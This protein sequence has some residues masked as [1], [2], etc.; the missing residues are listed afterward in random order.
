MPPEKGPDPEALAALDRLREQ[1]E[2]TLNELRTLLELPGLPP[3]FAGAAATIDL[4]ER[5]R[6]WQ[7]LSGPAPPN[8]S[9]TGIEI[10][11]GIQ[12]FRP[13][14]NISAVTGRTGV[15]PEND[16]PLVARKAT[17]L[18]IY[19]Q[20]VEDVSGT[21]EWRTMGTATWSPPLPALAQPLGAPLGDPLASR[22]SI[23]G[24]LNFRVPAAT[25]VGNLEVRLTFTA[26][27]H[28]HP[29][30]VLWDLQGHA[31]F[32]R[33]LGALWT[34]TNILQLTFVAVNPLGVRLVRM[35]Y[36]GRGLMLAAPTVA[37]F[38]STSVQLRRMYP[39]SDICLWRESEELYD[40]DFS[41]ITPGAQHTPGTPNGGTTGDWLHIMNNMIVLENA[42]G[43]VR[44]V[45]LYPNG[46][47]GASP[48]IGWGIGRTAL[49]PVDNQP[50]LAHEVGH[51]CGRPHAPCGGPAAPDPWY[52]TYGSYSSASIG[53][54]GIDIATLAIMDPATY[55]DF[56]SYCGPPWIS[57]YQYEHIRNWLLINPGPTTCI[58][59]A[60]AL[61]ARAVHEETIERLA[62]SLQIHRSGRVR[63]SQPCF[64]L[65][66]RAGADDG[67]K[68]DYFVE[69]CNQDADA[70][71]SLRL[72]LQDANQTLD[73]AVT[74][75]FALVPWNGAAA[76]IVVLRG[77]D[78]LVR[79]PIEGKAPR[80]SRPV[81]QNKKSTHERRLS[82]K[83][84]V[85]AARFAVRY[86]ANAGASWRAIATWLDQPSCEI[87]L[88]ALPGSDAGVFEIL[89]S[90]GFR[91]SR[92]SVKLGRVARGAMVAQIIFP[93]PKLVVRVGE[94]VI[95]LG[96]A[97]GKDGEAPIGSL[98]WSSS[99][100]GLLGAGREL[101]VH[102]LSA[103]RHV[104]TLQAPDGVG[105]VTRAARTITVRR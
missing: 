32:Q 7:R 66:V 64:H 56:M 14:V 20:D 75:Y 67:T 29:G 92:L 81:W 45:M 21:V 98:E 72:S 84:D 71:S 60:P 48:F 79:F 4:L 58:Q 74:S 24:S 95:L 5:L 55:R 93:K 31:H 52:P 9:V 34:A 19:F 90:A 44:Y 68:T 91:T 105:G 89:A 99:R 78:V 96:H 8:P 61:P 54:F 53:E 2:L 35:R 63:L 27:T 87:D 25:C 23:S 88:D 6:E 103:G 10:T 94:T 86:S 100:D 42:P 76:E 18:R 104:I 28:P 51:L 41:D 69:L 77:T 102:T 11:Q 30:R 73:D 17:I 80:I 83:C 13:P 85:P 38:W 57:P 59:M 36:E 40:G 97:A 62:L 43:A 37:D 16:L 47:V 3:R 39:L 70:L 1:F 101:M 50:A 15:Q 82:W 22:T 65:P 33:D 26:S 46:A 12:Y 49:T